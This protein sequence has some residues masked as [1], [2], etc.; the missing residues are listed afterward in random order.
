MAQY[1]I[2]A[3][4]LQI[5]GQISS[6]KPTSTGVTSS[7]TL[8]KRQVKTTITVANGEVLLIGGLNDSQAVNSLSS[9][10]FLPAS[11]G[12]NSSNTL[13]NDLVLIISANTR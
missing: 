5:D 9:L 3:N 6:F 8:I 13:E 12:V 2:G 10:P 4:K 7:P 1:W 11:W